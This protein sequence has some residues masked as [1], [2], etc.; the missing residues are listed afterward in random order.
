VPR[1]LSEQ[2]QRAEGAVV[3]RLVRTEAGAFF[4]NNNDAGVGG[5]S[6]VAENG[7]KAQV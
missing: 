3:G 6:K 4:E 5:G 2:W 1:Y 7:S